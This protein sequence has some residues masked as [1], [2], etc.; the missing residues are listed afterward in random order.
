MARHQ[1]RRPLHEQIRLLEAML[2]RHLQAVAHPL[3]ADEREPGSLAL[4][5]GVR[6][7]RGAVDDE[8][9]VGGREARSLEDLMGALE[10][11]TIRIGR[12]GQDLGRMA[13]PAHFEDGVRERP[14]DI[15]GERDPAGL[16]WLHGP[17][18]YRTAS[19]CRAGTENK[20]GPTP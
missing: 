6:R 9:D 12:G 20:K 14:P 15:D 7:Q 5:D 1:G 8:P 17:R 2:V 18:L 13:L 3:G 19:R 16:A 11:A 10:K 4:D